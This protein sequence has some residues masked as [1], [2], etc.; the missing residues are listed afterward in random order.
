MPVAELVE[1]ETATVEDRFD[2]DVQ[3]ITDIPAG[4]PLAACNSNTDDGCES[5]CASACVSGGV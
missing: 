5:T 2:L 3:I 1:V 4:H